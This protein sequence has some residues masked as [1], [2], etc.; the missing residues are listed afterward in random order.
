MLGLKCVLNL[1][2]SSENTALPVLPSPSL[3]L[4]TLL[5]VLC[6]LCSSALMYYCWLSWQTFLRSLFTD[7][8][9]VQGHVPAI[10]TKW[11]LLTLILGGETMENRSLMIG[12]RA[13][14]VWV[15]LS[16]WIC[17]QWEACDE[18]THVST[19]LYCLNRNT[20]ALLQTWRLGFSTWLQNEL[21][22]L[23]TL[24]EFAMC[25]WIWTNGD[26]DDDDEQIKRLGIWEKCWWIV[27]ID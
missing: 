25:V 21:L 23:S 1:P 7:M 15:N 2:D 5:G 12:S 11:L 14:C 27:L 26:D 20:A 19:L 17:L 3:P 6:S 24:N 10:M 16:E 18:E 4:Q 8:F 13:F 9:Y 22:E